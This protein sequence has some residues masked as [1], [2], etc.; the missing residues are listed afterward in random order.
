MAERHIVRH[1]GDVSPAHSLLRHQ[2]IFT[3][4]PRSAL[5]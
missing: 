5:A 1:I 3:S 4:P 2:A